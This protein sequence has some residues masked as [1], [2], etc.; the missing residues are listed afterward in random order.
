MKG[1][2]K[3]GLSRS[4][5]MIGKARSGSQPVIERN[6]NHKGM[7]LVKKRERRKSQ[8]PLL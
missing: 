6:V 5:T 7:C 1:V 4:L 2:P 8:M 3:E